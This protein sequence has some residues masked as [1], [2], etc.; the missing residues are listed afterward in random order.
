MLCLP[1]LV[2]VDL[3]SD[4]QVRVTEDELCIAGRDAQIL[5]GRERFTNRVEYLKLSIC[6]M[7]ALVLVDASLPLAQ[8]Q[9]A[10]IRRN[11]N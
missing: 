4:G 9:Q 11:R 2:G 1:V 7:L 3:L 6:E 10:V 8:M 5:T